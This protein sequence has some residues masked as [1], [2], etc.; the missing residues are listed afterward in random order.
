VSA[1]LLYNV[2][3]P[4]IVEVGAL[5]LPDAVEEPFHRLNAVVRQRVPWGLTLSLQARNLIDL[6]ATRSLGGRTVESV[7]R[8]RTFSVGLG[9]AW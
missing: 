1:A 7:T 4:R 5:G 6:P 8:G 3:G 9:W 2:F